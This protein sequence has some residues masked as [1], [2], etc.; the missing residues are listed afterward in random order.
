[1]PSREM[2]PGPIDWIKK[3]INDIERKK[4]D[5]TPDIQPE[6]NDNPFP[7]KDPSQDDNTPSQTP[8]DEKRG[9]TIINPNEE[10]GDDGYGWGERKPDP[11]IIQI[12]PTKEDDK[13]DNDK[14]G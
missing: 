9:V 5:K 2:G 13:P 4:K 7:E 12:I 10:N 3:K 11:N 1:M 8:D 6:I 14:K